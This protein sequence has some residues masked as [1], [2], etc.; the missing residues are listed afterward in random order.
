MCINSPLQGTEEAQ[1]SPQPGILTR[2]FLFLPPTYHVLVNAA[3]A[4]CSQ[5]LISLY[6]HGCYPGDC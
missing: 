4:P 6:M 5:E 1:E 2:L 3:E